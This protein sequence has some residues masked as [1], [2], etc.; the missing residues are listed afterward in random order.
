MILTKT[1]DR[2]TTAE[3]IRPIRLP[4]DLLQ[5]ASLLD[6]AFSS[7]LEMT[8]SHMIEDLRQA[9]RLG[10]LLWM[11]SGS[12]LDGFVYVE[13]ELLVGNIT[14]TQEPRD[15]TSWFISNVAVL[16]DWRG[17]GIASRLLD[18]ALDYLRSRHARW[19]RLQVRTEHPVALGLYRR[20]G[21]ITYDTTYELK[22]EARLL[23]INL[24]AAD[25]R[26]RPLRPRDSRALWQ[27]VLNTSAPVLIRQRV[28][29]PSD[30]RRTWLSRLDNQ[31]DAWLVGNTRY[32]LV[33]Y[34]GYKLAAYAALSA[35]SARSSYQC[36]LRVLPQQRGMWEE[37]LIRQLALHALSQPRRNVLASVPLTHP[38][39][40]DALLKSGFI[41]QRTLAQMSLD[42]A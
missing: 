11:T 6:I 2:G 37:A 26:L 1:L 29:R 17:Q 32:E 23:D 5:L 8:D 31:L 22:L 27:L 13:D 34:D 40:L 15:P 18:T 21:F 4:Q 19:A 28:L 7:E 10:A 3:G 30:F 36:E 38:E 24:A 25:R 39:A 35:D 9:A 12:R 20:R 33:G 42:I 16:P 14:L 41:C